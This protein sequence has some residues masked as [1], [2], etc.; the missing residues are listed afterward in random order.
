MNEGKHLTIEGLNLIRKIK[1]KMNKS[2]K[3]D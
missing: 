3:F 1:N 2:R